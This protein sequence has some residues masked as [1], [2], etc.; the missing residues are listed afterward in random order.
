MVRSAVVLLSALLSLLLLCTIAP[1]AAAP[2][3]LSA[4]LVAL[5]NQAGECGRDGAGEGVRRGAGTK[6]RDASD[7]RTLNDTCCAPFLAAT[8]LPASVPLL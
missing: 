5:L 4:P 6:S 7:G 8:T 2:P 1:A 3:P